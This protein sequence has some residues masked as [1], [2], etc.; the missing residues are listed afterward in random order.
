[1]KSCFSR[2]EAGNEE[3]NFP[4]LVKTIFILGHHHHGDDQDHGDDDD[5]NW[6]GG[7]LDLHL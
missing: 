4:Y 5:D 6:D 3:E 1:M 2:E 7:K